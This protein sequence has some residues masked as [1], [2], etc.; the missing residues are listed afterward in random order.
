MAKIGKVGSN[1]ETEVDAD[2]CA[3]TGLP[4]AAG[5]ARVP[6]AGTPFF[7]R[8]NALAF[9]KMT[10]EDHQRIVREASGPVS[11]ARPKKTEGE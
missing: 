9:Q 6:I 1:G 7:Y 3:L 4:I 10:A 8:V 5:D 11:V 2:E